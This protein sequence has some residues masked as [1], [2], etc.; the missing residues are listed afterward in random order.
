MGNGDGRVSEQQLPYWLQYTRLT[1]PPRQ[2]P[3]AQVLG[4]DLSRIQPPWVP[5]NSTFEVDDAESEWI[6]PPEH[7]DYIHMRAMA[8]CFK[9]WKLI[10]SRVLEHLQ[11]GGY[12]ELQDHGAMLYTAEPD[13]SVLSMEDPIDAPP[14]SPLAGWWNFILRAARENGTPF[15]IASGIP[16]LL[17]ELG[18]EEVTV[19]KC[20][21]PL[22]PW[23]EIPALDKMGEWGRMGMVESLNSFSHNMMGG[24]AG[25]E[26]R[27][28]LMSAMDDLM[29]EE[30][31][32]W[33][34]TCVAW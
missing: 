27:S 26:V 5:E 2:Y 3:E 1:L 19:K 30:S 7:F 4:N 33:V 15:Q 21:W 17:K 25:S 14:S 18:F 23:P 31:R 9:D 6:F 32:Y 12:F 34:Q 11:P 16:E 28:M 8:G 24:K 22:T 10:L 13:R 20:A 29:R